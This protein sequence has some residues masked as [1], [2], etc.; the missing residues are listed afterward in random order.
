MGDASSSVASVHVPL[1]VRQLSSTHMTMMVMKISSAPFT[2]TIDK[3][4]VHYS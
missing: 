1:K 4:K 3:N 2:D